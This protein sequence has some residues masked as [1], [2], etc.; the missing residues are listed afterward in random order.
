MTRQEFAS[1]ALVVLSWIAFGSLIGSGFGFLYYARLPRVYQA[2]VDV[3]LIGPEYSNHDVSAAQD[4]S[5]L[6]IGRPNLSAAVQA[7]KLHHLPEFRKAGYSIDEDHTLEMLQ[8][9]DSLTVEPISNLQT[10]VVAKIRCNAATPSSAKAILDA[11]VSEYQRSMPS[12]GDQQQWNESLALI[13]SASDAV[14]KDIQLLEEHRKTLEIPV[15]TVIRDGELIS[16]AKTIWEQKKREIDEQ[17]T[18]AAELSTKMKECISEIDRLES[19]NDPEPKTPRLTA[20]PPTNLAPAGQAELRRKVE[21]QLAPMQRELDK[22]LER[23][24]NAH[25]TVVALR[26]RMDDV[27]A[28]LDPISDPPRPKLIPSVT[29]EE[30]PA[31]NRAEEI[32]RLK[33]DLESLRKKR[34]QIDASIGQMLQALDQAAVEMSRQERVVR[35][36]NL[37]ENELEILRKLKSEMLARLEGL[38]SSPPFASSELTILK[39]ASPGVQIA[40][41]LRPL[42][43]TGAFWG[44]SSGL[45]VSLV[46]ALIGLSSGPNSS[47]TVSSEVAL[48]AANEVSGKTATNA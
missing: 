15:N 34:E 35:R 42:L 26:A 29:R 14:Q 21:R 6:I 33:R 27:R 32:E 20:S 16:S 13:Q 31:F 43:K 4:D 1:L 28:Q 10:G 37:I 36:L 39:P 48:S 47:T 25:P 24:G 38:G 12:V 2:S 41:E 11:I 40:P 23:L 19:E 17:Q 44:A 18:S 3:Q 45:L 46:M 5:R 9:D 30:K 8:Q 7:A 22:L